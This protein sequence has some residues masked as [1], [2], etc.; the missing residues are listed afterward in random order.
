MAARRAPPKK[1]GGVRGRKTNPERRAQ[2]V[3]EALLGQP[4][5]IA[6]QY[7]ISERTLQRWI[8]GA[9][10]DPALSAI[11]QKNKRAIHEDWAIAS[12]GTLRRGLAALDTLFDSVLESAKKGYQKGMIHEVAGAVHLVGNLKVTRDALGSDGDEPAP[13]DSEG[14]DPP[15]DEGEAPGGAEG[16][17]DAGEE[18]HPFH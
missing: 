1:L 14:Q 3:A 10:A 9:Q 7:G 4:A 15:E 5:T 6:K 2:I 17:E 11:V 12:V 16:E 13:D 18:E 8:K